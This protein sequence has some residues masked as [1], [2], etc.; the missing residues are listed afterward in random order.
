MEQ[1][2]C[3]AA[4]DR[5][6]PYLENTMS[7]MPNPPSEY[8]ACEDGYYFRN[9]AYLPFSHIGTWMVSFFTGEGL[10]AWRR[11]GE[12]R[13]LKWA[14]GFAEAYRRKLTDTPEDTMHDVGFLYVLYA[15]GLYRETGKETYREMAVKAAEI[16]L[17]RFDTEAEFIRAWGRMDVKEHHSAGLAIIDCMMN[18]SLLFFA[19][20]ETGKEVFRETAMRH[21]DRT[22]ECF[23][24][25]DGSV[26]H[27]YQYREAGGVPVGE[28]NHC[29]FGKGS[30]W[31]R[32]LAWAVFGYGNC[33]RHTK[34]PMYLELARKL[35]DRFLE[36]TAAAEQTLCPGGR[37]DNLVPPWDFRLP[38]GAEKWRDSSAAAIAAC[39]FD[40]IFRACG[41]NRYREAGERILEALSGPEYMNPDKNS[42]GILLHS[43]GREHCTSF[44]DYFYMEALLRY[45]Q[46]FEGYW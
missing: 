46:G 24:R 16:L 32:G 18:L 21:A 9:P 39:G 14:E 6:L 29:G 8:A 43:N 37:R 19:W 28:V 5:C 17:G 1:S 33:Y 4:F 44:G 10:L 13:Y 42:S 7:K 35:A 40:E 15:V 38:E 3:R 45:G 23:I 20:R 12:E 36:E 25:P 31:A 26:C 30:F 27:G 34:K 41:E 22:A 2:Q 11:K